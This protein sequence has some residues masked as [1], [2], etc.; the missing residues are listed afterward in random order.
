M[1]DVV[2]L[3]LG[4]GSLPTKADYAYRF[5]IVGSCHESRG[6]RTYARSENTHSGLAFIERGLSS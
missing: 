4:P 3:P 6:A 2:V 1:G 5:R